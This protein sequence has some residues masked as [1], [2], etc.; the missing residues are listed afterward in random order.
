MFEQ[1]FI[2]RQIRQLAAAIARLINLEQTAVDTAGQTDLEQLSR[3]NV[4]L[5]LGTLRQ[6]PSEQLDLLLSIGGDY[7]CV[8]AVM[9]G[10]LL[11]RDSDSVMERQATLEKALR[12]LATARDHFGGFLTDEHEAAFERLHNR[13]SPAPGSAS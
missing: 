2:M 13:L 10:L 4:H 7:D 6:L 1:D 3:N 12:M 8:R 11:E 5:S 9:I